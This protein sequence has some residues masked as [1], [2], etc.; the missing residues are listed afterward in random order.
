MRISF[1]CINIFLL[2]ILLSCSSVPKQQNFVFIDTD[3]G[4]DDLIAIEL[5]LESDSVQISGIS[6]VHGLT[7]VE[8]GAKIVRGL[9]DHYGYFEVPVFSGSNKPIFPTDKFP[10]EWKNQSTEIGF[11]LINHKCDTTHIIKFDANKIFEIL[12]KKKH[13]I[14]A[15]GPL[16]NIYNLISND[17]G[18]YLKSLRTVIMGGALSVTGNLPGSGEFITENK[19]AEWNFYSDPIAA[20]NCLEYLNNIILIPLDAT[21][22]V[23]IDSSYLSQDKWKFRKK[24]LT[25]NIFKNVGNWIIEDQ[26][27]AWDPLAAAYIINRNVINVDS[28]AIQVSMNKN[29]IGRTELI[30]L[31]KKIQFGISGNKVIFDE[32]IFNNNSNN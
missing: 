1:I 14:L 19:F 27:F 5:L 30:D 32:V 9:L 26:Y 17:K 3:C 23:K 13:T 16:T 7:N 11:N 22:T 25:F 8:D 15:L 4:T 24:N 2:L 6:C 21:N 10:E 29:E 20:K 31:G 18:G 12:K 28:S